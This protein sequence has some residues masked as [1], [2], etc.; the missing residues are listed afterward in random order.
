MGLDAGPASLVVG[1]AGRQRDQVALLEERRDGVRE[2]D[3]GD[4]AVGLVLGQAPLRVPA[5]VAVGA[6]EVGEGD[7]VG[8]GPGVELVV[9]LRGEIGPVVGDVGPAVRVGRDDV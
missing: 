2:E 8:G 4:D 7:L 6:Q 1:L 5:A 9:E 3:L